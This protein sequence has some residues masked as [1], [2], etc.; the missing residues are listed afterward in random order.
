MNTK[1]GVASIM[2]KLKKA[3]D[4]EKVA[5]ILGVS[6]TQMLEGIISVTETITVLSDATI[7]CKQ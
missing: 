6:A 7:E 2:E 3:V 5:K 1:L 4:L